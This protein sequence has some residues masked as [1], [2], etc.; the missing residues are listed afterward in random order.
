MS[1]GFF[2]KF[3]SKKEVDSSELFC[4]YTQCDKCGEKFKTLIRKNNDLAPTY[5]NEGPAFILR[6]ELIGASCP[7]RINL[8]LEFD[9]SYQKISEEITGGH[10]I[11]KE[12]YQS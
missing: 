10:F 7:N 11:S 8:Y 1:S 3:F 5:K 12:E 2:K 6:K 9:R 4:I